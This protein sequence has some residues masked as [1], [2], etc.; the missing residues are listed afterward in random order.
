M[1]P[2][3]LWFI[4]GWTMEKEFPRKYFSCI[5]L[6]LALVLMAQPCI[7]RADSSDTKSTF[8]VAWLTVPIEGRAFRLV[9]HIFR[10]GGAG[11]FPLVVINHGTPVSIAD[12][13]KQ[14]PGF[15]NASK[16]F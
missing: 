11:P 9:A 15:S 14:K 6:I 16:W 5:G 10:P 7:T 2:I 12:A 4:Q 13:R 1:N 3:G 8:E